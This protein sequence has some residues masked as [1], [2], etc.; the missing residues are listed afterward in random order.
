MV[1]PR[2]H[3]APRRAVGVGVGVP[4]FLFQFEERGGFRLLAVTDGPGGEFKHPALRLWRY[5]RTRTRFPSAVTWTIM[6]LGGV[7]AL[8]QSGGQPSCPV[9]ASTITRCERGPWWRRE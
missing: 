3:R 4:G 9:T 2:A 6:T 1:V 7:S 5:W 8:Y